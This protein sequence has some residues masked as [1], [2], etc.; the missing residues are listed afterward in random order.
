M[1]QPFLERKMR[2][3]RGFGEK[4]L[5]V[6][7]FFLLKVSKSLFFESRKKSFHGLQPPCR[8]HPGALQADG[9]AQFFF[10]SLHDFIGFP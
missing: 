3:M 6:I 4:N 5:A 7:E 1:N 2:A 8:D 10:A 9:L